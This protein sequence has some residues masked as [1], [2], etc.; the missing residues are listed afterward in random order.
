MVGVY[1]VF[2]QVCF[3]CCSVCFM[4]LCV[5]VRVAMFHM[6]LFVFKI[7]FLLCVCVSCS[8]V[9]VGWAGWVGGQVLHYCVCFICCV[10]VSAGLVGKCFIGVCFVN[11]VSIIVC[12]IIFVSDICEVYCVF[13]SY[14]LCGCSWT[15]GVFFVYICFVLDFV[16]YRSWVLFQELVN[17]YLHSVISIVF[18]HRC[19]SLWFWTLRICLLCSYRVTD[20]V[21]SDV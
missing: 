8:R 16:N 4:W 1:F 5:L 6:C 20:S 17:L 15:I 9:C 13:C 19:F 14:F 10:C 18:L 11:Y 7:L 12:V 2:W 21:V 3:I